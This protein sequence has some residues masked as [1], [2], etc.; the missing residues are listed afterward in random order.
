MWLCRSGAYRFEVTV[1]GRKPTC[2][3]DFWGAEE[4]PWASSALLILRLYGVDFI[5]VSKSV[6]TL[7]LVPGINFL[8]PQAQTCQL[9]LGMPGRFETLLLYKSIS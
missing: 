9:L 2:R 4:L 7:V 6:V 3:K 5:G 1:G 8:Y